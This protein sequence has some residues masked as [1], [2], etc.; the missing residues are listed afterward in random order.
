M[1][2]RVSLKTRFDTV[3]Y[4]SL[5]HANRIDKVFVY[6]YKGLLLFNSNQK[7]SGV[8]VWLQGDNFRKYSLRKPW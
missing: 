1:T 3:W 6:E 2:S 8:Q 4:A 5:K 7:K